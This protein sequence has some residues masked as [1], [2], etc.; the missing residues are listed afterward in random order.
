M[1][2]H[3]KALE[4]KRE[5]DAREIQLRQQ[6]ADGSGSNFNLDAVVKVRLYI[7]DKREIEEILQ[8]NTEYENLSHFIRCAIQR[9]IRLNRS[10]LMRVK[11]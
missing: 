5:R 1:S 4:L 2:L 9:E 11:R 6:N 3:D 8:R 7:D 10:I